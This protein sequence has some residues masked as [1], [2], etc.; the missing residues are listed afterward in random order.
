MTGSESKS[1]ASLRIANKDFSLS[2]EIFL[3]FIASVA[4][5]ASKA[6]AEVKQQLT[7]VW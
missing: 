1:S 5:A 7:Q 3:A 6:I 2:A 4:L